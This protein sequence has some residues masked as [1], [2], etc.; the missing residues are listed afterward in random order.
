MD[1]TIKK[2]YISI[3]QFTR[4]YFRVLNNIGLRHMVLPSWSV[5]YKEKGYY[6]V[7]LLITG[8]R[9]WDR[10]HDWCLKN[11]GA[12]HYS[13]VFDEFFFE[14]EKDMIYFSLAWL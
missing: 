7:R 14:T 1:I 10:I 13:W 4:E 11:I 8:K 12:E 6:G 3:Q 5:I 2:E 9:D